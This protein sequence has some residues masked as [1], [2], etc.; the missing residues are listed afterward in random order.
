MEMSVPVSNKKNCFEFR[1]LRKRRVEWKDRSKSAH[2]DRKFSLNYCFF[3]ELAP[4]LAFLSTFTKSKMLPAKWTVF[5]K[6]CFTWS[7]VAR[8]FWHW[9]R[10]KWSFY[11]KLLN[12]IAKL[13]NFTF[14]TY[15]T[16]WKNIW[17][18]ITL[19]R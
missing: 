3:F 16:Y 13:K 7:F 4:F 10:R 5:V 19:P 14:W 17:N 2:F 9:M 11:R 18:C 6:L 15:C 8:A 1:S 12:F